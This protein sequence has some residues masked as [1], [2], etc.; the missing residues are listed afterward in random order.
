MFKIKGTTLLKIYLYLISFITL[1]V[2]V[3]MGAIVFKAGINS[4]QITSKA[5]QFQ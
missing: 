1:T 3:F 2:S 5:E 4:P